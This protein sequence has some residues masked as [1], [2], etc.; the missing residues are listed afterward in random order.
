MGGG[1]TSAIFTELGR[2]RDTLA[3][4]TD[5]EI[6]WHGILPFMQRG[7]HVRLIGAYSV[8]AKDECNAGASDAP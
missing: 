7:L 5:H 6:R 2:A 1:D 3:V 8:R 4:D